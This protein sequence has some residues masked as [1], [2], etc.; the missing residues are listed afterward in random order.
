[1]I[2]KWEAIDSGL[3]LSTSFGFGLNR[4][5]RGILGLGKRNYSM[6]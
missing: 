1:M 3:L 5:L 6:N 2:W 4:R